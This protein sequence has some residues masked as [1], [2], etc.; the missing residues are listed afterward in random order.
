MFSHINI[1][2]AKYKRNSQFKIYLCIDSPNKDERQIDLYKLDII[3]KWNKM[4]SSCQE[5]PEKNVKYSP[6]KCDKY[7]KIESHNYLSFIAKSYQIVNR[8]LI[9]R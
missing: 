2:F 6:I 4:L 1:L 8:S 3:G 9:K 7:L 5:R